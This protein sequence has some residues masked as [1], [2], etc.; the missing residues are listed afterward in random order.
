MGKTYLRYV[1]AG[2]HGVVAS[3]GCAAVAVSADGGLAFTG[4]LE[5]VGV[6]DLKRGLEVRGGGVRGRRRG[7]GAP[8]EGERR[9]GRRRGE[10]RTERPPPP[11]VTA[12][13]PPHP[14]AHPDR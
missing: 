12:R 10:R 1:P 7:G 8:A 5:R 4:Q 13:P 6:W 11:R 14:H 9:R 2:V 3:P